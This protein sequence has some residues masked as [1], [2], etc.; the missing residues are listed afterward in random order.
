MC[1]LR[2]T[3]YGVKFCFCM[4][5]FKSGSIFANKEKEAISVLLT[6]SVHHVKF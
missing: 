4:Y 5:F 3:K 1:I 6:P 2:L